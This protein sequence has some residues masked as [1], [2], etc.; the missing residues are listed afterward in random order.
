VTLKVTVAATEKGS[1]Y[2]GAGTYNIGPSINAT[3]PTIVHITGAGSNVTKANIT[4]S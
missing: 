4:L 1:A 3:S 2:F